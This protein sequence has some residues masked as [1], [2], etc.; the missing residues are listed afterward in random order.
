[1]TECG[2]KNQFDACA[3]KSSVP[4][5]RNETFSSNIRNREESSFENVDV[6]KGGLGKEGAFS[7]QS[8]ETNVR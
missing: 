2:N 5:M 1:M 7:A 3:V 6:Q 4:T 8:G